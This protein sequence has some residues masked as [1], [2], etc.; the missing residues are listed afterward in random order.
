[1]KN[2]I[3]AIAAGLVLFVWTSVSWTVLPWRDAA[4]EKLPNEQLVMQNLADSAPKSGLYYIPGDEADYTEDTPT[5][6]INIKKEGFQVGFAGMMIKGL[7]LD[8]VVA[9]LAVY[10]L[11]MARGLS[12][13]K[14]VGFVTLTG[15]LIGIAGN[16]F[17]WNW[18][19]FPGYYTIIQILDSIIMWFLAGLVL[20][21]LVP[22]RE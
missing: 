8:I 2:I 20:A 9:L 10:L 16:G 13:K 1:M 18:F 12:F 6:F 21:K 15:V 14:R 3:A 22:E 4:V 11:S 19:A 17:Y 5:A 7:I